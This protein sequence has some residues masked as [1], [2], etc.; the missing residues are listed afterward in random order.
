MT[1][2][3]LEVAPTSIEIRALQILDVLITRS[4][5]LRLVRS[6]PWAGLNPSDEVL[7]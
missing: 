5:S 4:L 7:A 1:A 2:M 6:A 3:P